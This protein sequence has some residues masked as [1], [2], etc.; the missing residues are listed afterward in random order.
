MTNLEKLDSNYV[1]IFIDDK[2]CTLWIWQGSNVSTRMKL[3]VAKIAPSI[4]NN[5]NSDYKIVAVDEGNEPTS[6]KER[7]ENGGTP[8]NL[9]DIN[10]T[11]D[12]MPISLK[13][14]EKK[15]ICTHCGSKIAKDQKICTSCGKMVI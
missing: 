11:F 7:V 5:F 1:L 15:I 8:I 9:E 4:R 10:L 12:G 3:M 14:K 6:F 2:R 13:S